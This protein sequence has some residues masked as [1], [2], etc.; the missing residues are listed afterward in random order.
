MFT[1]TCILMLNNGMPPRVAGN[2]LSSLTGRRTS[3]C[4]TYG[5][6]VWSSKNMRSWQTPYSH[7]SQPFMLIVLRHV[8][9]HWKDRNTILNV[10]WVTGFT[11]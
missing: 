9:L 1:S 6:R 8:L 2:R 7:I 11:V 4:M 10:L 3:V 5:D